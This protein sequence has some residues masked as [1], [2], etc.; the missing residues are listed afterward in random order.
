MKGKASS[1]LASTDVTG[2]SLTTDLWTSIAN[3]PYIG[4][5]GHFLDSKWKLKSVMLTVEE[6]DERHT[7]KNIA[8]RLKDIAVL[9]RIDD[10]VSAVIRDNAANMVAT[11]RVLREMCGWNDVSYVG[12]TLQLC[13]E[14]GLD[15]ATI[16]MMLAKARKIVR[17]F[18]HSALATGE[19]CTACRNGTNRRSAALYETSPQ[20]EIPLSS[21]FNA[22]CRRRQLSTPYSKMRAS[23][24]PATAATLY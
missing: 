1:L 13:V 15:G 4:V 10:K 18:S 3:D 8:A 11:T 19:S 17:H 5:T 7:G 23:R 6:M 12:H 20:C 24:S 2:I 22:S 9:W 21:C 14:E 16:S